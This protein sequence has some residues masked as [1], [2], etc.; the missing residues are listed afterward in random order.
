MGDDQSQS[1]GGAITSSSRPPSSSTQ[2]ARPPGMSSTN[3]IA[4]PSNPAEPEVA[5]KK[6]KKKK[7]KKVA[8][9]L[10]FESDGPIEDPDDGD[11]NAEVFVVGEFLTPCLIIP[12]LTLII[13]DRPLISIPL[14]ADAIVYAIYKPFSPEKGIPGC[15]WHYHNLWHNYPLA[16]T[17]HEEPI[18]HDMFDENTTFVKEFWQHARSSFEKENKLIARASTQRKG[19]HPSEPP[20]KVGD[21]VYTPANLF[22]ESSF[23]VICTR[24]FMESGR[25]SVKLIF[26]FHP[27]AGLACVIR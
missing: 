2:A 1:T 21:V 17:S 10:S 3:A 22:R 8:R 23:R 19:K 12:C 25:P 20:A 13:L 7:K 26:I 14:L 18:T 16:Q 11:L 27:G 6:K 15:G 5:I 4:G 9:E 24:P